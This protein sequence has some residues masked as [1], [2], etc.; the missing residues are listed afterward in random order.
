MEKKEIHYIWIYWESSTG[1]AHSRLV[2]NKTMPFESAKEQIKKMNPEVFYKSRPDW[3]KDCV[4]IVVSAQNII[5]R[6]VYYK[7]IINIKKKM[8]G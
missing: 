1:S 2:S 5:D 8:V 7:R 4:R 3:L 6:S